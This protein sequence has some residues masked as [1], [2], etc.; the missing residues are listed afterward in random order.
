MSLDDDVLCSDSGCDVLHFEILLKSCKFR[1]I[2]LY[3]PP[4]SDRYANIALA[5]LLSSL[6]DPHTNIQDTTIIL[7]DFNL[8]C[9]DWSNSHV[10][11]DGI[12]DFMFN[13]M[14]SLGMSQ[15]VTQPTRIAN[16]GHSS[17]LDLIFSND[18]L[19]IDVINYLPPFSTSDH[20]MIEFVI[21]CNYDLTT[22]PVDAGF[23]E[24]YLPT[25]LK[26]TT[27]K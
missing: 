7:G 11:F 20:M 22:P 6:V 8:P 17:I 23:N 24:T 14:S 13:C 16:S 5:K 19:S 9:I 18:P 27:I 25:G 3:R 15:L 2:F 1:I 10:K 21:Y 4:N 26:V 12:H